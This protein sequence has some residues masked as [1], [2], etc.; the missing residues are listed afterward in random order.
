MATSISN[1]AQFLEREN[2]VRYQAGIGIAAGVDGIDG[3]KYPPRIYCEMA[4]VAGGCGTR[5]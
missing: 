1:A 2:T 5:R 4:V 3:V